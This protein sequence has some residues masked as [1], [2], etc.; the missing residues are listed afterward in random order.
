[1]DG[2]GACGCPGAVIN[3]PAMLI[4]LMIMVLLIV[5]VYAKALASTPQ[6]ST[7]KIV[8]VL[9]F[10]AAGVCYVEPA[11]WTPFMPLRTVG[12]HDWRG[13]VFFAYIGFDAVSRQRPRKPE[14]AP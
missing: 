3:L 7:I 13:G 1:M 6:W 11:N 2:R 4:V 9:F 14:S 8:A 12:R 10:L 5:G